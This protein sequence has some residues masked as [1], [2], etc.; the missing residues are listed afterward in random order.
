LLNCQSGKHWDYECKHSW[1]GEKQARANFSTLSDPEIEALSAYDDL[2]YGLE[3]N[4]ESA[5]DQQDFCQPFQ[6][7]D[8]AL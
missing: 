5:K 3:S 8:Q 2:Y 1:K 6:S 4:N 7:S